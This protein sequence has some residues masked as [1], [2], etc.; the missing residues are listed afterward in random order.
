MQCQPPS[1][2]CCVLLYSPCSAACCSGRLSGCLPR[3]CARLA[4][5]LLPVL[6][7]CAS[8]ELTGSPLRPCTCL[9][10]YDVDEL[11]DVIEGSRV[12]IPC[13]YAV[14]KID[15]ASRR[16]ATTQMASTLAEAA[17]GHFPGIAATR[18]LCWNAV[19]QLA[20][21]ADCLLGPACPPSPCR[22]RLRSS[23]FWTSCR[24]TA[25]CVHITRCG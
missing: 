9:Q 20:A 5:S 21:S 2:I 1:H 22:S 14:N 24:T 15:Q 8:H 3:G 4:P 11:I 19:R 13:I 7:S 18:N 25:P 17:C 10:D 23:M 6:Q 16:P 12:Y